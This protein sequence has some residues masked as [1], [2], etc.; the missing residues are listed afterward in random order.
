MIIFSTLG[1]KYGLKLVQRFLAHVTFVTASLVRK[2][3]Y[4]L[5]NHVTYPCQNVLL[6]NLFA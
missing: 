1:I 2:T 3:S 4:E 6:T 5:N